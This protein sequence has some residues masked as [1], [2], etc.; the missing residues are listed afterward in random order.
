MCS[1]YHYSQSC[2]GWPSCCWRYQCWGGPVWRTEED[3]ISVSGEHA[4]HPGISHFF[5][6]PSAS[7]AAFVVFLA[8]FAPSVNLVG[9]LEAMEAGVLPADW[10]GGFTMFDIGS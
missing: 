8:A 6:S 2:Y 4:M 10:R 5:F 1:K 3:V 9:A 7:A